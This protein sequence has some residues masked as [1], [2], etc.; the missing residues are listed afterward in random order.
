MQCRLY[1]GFLKRLI[2]ENVMTNMEWTEY[3]FSNRV[4]M[5]FAASLNGSKMGMCW[6]I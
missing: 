5:D 2:V 1:T 6:C 4:G 3:I